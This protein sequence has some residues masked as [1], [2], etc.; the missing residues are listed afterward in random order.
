MKTKSWT[1][2][3]LPAAVVLALVV[4]STAGA[5]TSWHGSDYAWDYNSETAMAVCDAEVDGNTAYT[6]FVVN[7]SGSTL[8]LDDP[9]E[10]GWDCGYSTG[11]SNGIYSHQVCE[12]INNWPD[13][14]GSKVYP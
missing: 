5:L 14:C 3:L 9:D 11:W 12:D 1:R 4:P 7:G 6:K 13:D 8:R 2:R 10:D